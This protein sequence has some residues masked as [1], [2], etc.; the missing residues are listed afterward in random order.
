MNKF[1]L[2]GLL[3]ICCLFFLPLQGQDTFE[4]VVIDVG[5]LGLSVTNVGTI[6]RPDVRND[7]QGD[8][9]FEYPLNSGIEHLFEAGLWIGAK[10]D[11]QLRLTTGAIDATAGYFTGGSGFELTPQSSNSLKERSTLTES[12]FFSID[13]VSHQDV[14]LKFTDSNTIVPGTSIPIQDHANPLDADITCEAYAWNFSFADFF[15]ILNYSI[16]NNSTAAWDSVYLGLWTDLVVRNVNVTTESGVAFFN[17][18]GGGFLSEYNALY[19]FDVAGEPEFT[20][21]YGASQFLG[22]EW[23]DQ[24]F[25]PSNADLFTNQG[26]PAP[27]VHANF[28]NFR[29]FDGTDFSAPFTVDGQFVEDVAYD[30]MKQGL[31]FSIPTIREDVQNPNNRTQL[32]SAGPLV[33]IAPGET[34]NFALALVAAKQLSTGANTGPE[35]D[36]EF[37]RTELVEHLGWA[38]RTFNGEDLNENG[39]LDDGEDLND[40]NQLDRYILPEPPATPKVHLEV[41]NNEVAVYWD[42]AAESS[43]D[44]ISKKED[45]EGYRVYRTEV[46]DD[47]SLDMIGEAEL[48]AQWDT[49]GNSIGFNNGFDN[50]TLSQPVQFEGDETNYTYKFTNTGLLNGW[51]YLYIITSFDQGDADLGLGSLESSFVANAKRVFVGTPATEDPDQY[52]VGVYPNPYRI[53]AAWDGSSARTKKIHFYNLP[54]RS[55]IRIYTLAGDLV[56]ELSHNAEEYIGQDIQWYSDFGG[57]EN[58]RIFPGGEHAWNLLSESNQAVTQ[59]LYL[60]TVKNLDSGHVQKG[61]FAILK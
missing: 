60:Y 11:G 46:G 38:Q 14:V 47:F 54:P 37:A 25:H 29:T 19:A 42:N 12:S 45:F 57:A 7:P 39:L 53:E 52:P 31:D 56:A 4:S 58:Q 18:G 34:V 48:V 30:K 22:I 43:V 23:R 13:A 20:S 15:V 8:P 33:E 24:F 21:S 59:G 17:K 35:M 28:W 3:T 16:T 61:Q 6:G 36:T 40:N 55:E 49:E 50:I 9:S 27:E 26:L 5:N 2:A 10:V 51:Q 32:L 41:N 1:R 44:P